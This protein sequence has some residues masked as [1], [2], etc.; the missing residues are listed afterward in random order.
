MNIMNQ[1]ILYEKAVKYVYENSPINYD[2]CMFK[3]WKNITYEV[4]A[5][6]LGN[7]VKIKSTGLL[8]TIIEV[9]MGQLSL[10]T[11]NVP[12]KILPIMT[13]LDNIEIL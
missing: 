5:I 10:V 1:I 12:N 13:E 11:V 9:N 6:L 4:D 3:L 2:L 8:G 7:A